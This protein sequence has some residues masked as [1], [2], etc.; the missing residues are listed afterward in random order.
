MAE[1]NTLAILTNKQIIFIFDFTEL[2]M[3]MTYEEKI[4]KAHDCKIDI[5]YDFSKGENVVGIYKF[6]YYNQ[7]EEYCFYIGK[8]TNIVDRLLGSSDGH[9][10]MYLK[11]K[12]TKLVPK[13]INEY[14]R[15]GYKIKVVIDEINYRDT[16]FSKAAH[17][18][19]L[20]ELQE[21]VKYQ[22]MGQCQFQ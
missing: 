19:A 22:E 18:I 12:F 21:I 11:K 3:R 8:S 16:S 10:Y 1:V 2:V 14:L 6:F 13:K 17:R 5:M 7:D 4:K 9:I 20:A 15:K